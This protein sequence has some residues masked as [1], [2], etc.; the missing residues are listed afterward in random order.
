MWS[1]WQVHTRREKWSAILA[2]SWILCLILYVLPLVPAFT[3]YFA[4]WHSVLSLQ[5]IT[6]HLRQHF[7]MSIRQVILRAIPLTL[8]SLSAI[9][10]FL[11]F[12]GMNFEFSRVIMGTLM[13]ISIL[14]LPHMGIMNSM[15]SGLQGSIPFMTDGT[16]KH[17]TE[18]N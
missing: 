12:G 3:F 18:L 6:R 8:I 2:Q 16:I 13:S 1:A 9:S 5:A 10:A 17:S 4:I 15:Y 11:W 14:T 7:A